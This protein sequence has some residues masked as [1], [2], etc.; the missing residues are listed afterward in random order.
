MKYIYLN[1]DRAYLL[2]FARLHEPGC[3]VVRR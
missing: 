2:N 3:H 1:V